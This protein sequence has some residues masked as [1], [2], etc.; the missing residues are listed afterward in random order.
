MT[1][2]GELPRL[3]VRPLAI[4]LAVQVACLTALSGRYGF[5]RDELYFIAAGNHIAPGYID[6]PPI[7]P[8]LA[9]ISVDLFGDTT[10]GLRVVSTVMAMLTVVLVAL[11]ARE[12]GSGRGPQLFAAGAAALSGFVLVVS[13]LVSTSSFDL[14]MWMLISWL[15]LRV[16]RTGD[17]RWWLG[18]GLAVGLALE[19]KWLVV[20]LLA[21]VAIGLIVVGPRTVFRTWWLA[22]GIGVAVLILLP[23]LIWQIQHHFPQ[24]T[25]ASQISATDGGT[26]RIMFIPLQLV[27]LSPVLVPVWF[28]GIRRIWRA[29]ELRW[30]RSLV[31]AYPVLCVALLIVGGKP[32][33]PVPLLLVFLAAGAEPSMAAV[34]WFVTGERTLA[35]V[36]SW[37]G[38]VVAVLISAAISLPV[39]PQRDLGPVLAI[40]PDQGEEVAWPGFVDAVAGAWQ[41]I[42]AGERDTAV[43]LTDNYGE[44][45]AIQ[46]YGYLDGLPTPYSGHM[47]YS[48]WGPPADSMTGPVLLVGQFAPPQ[49]TDCRLI[50][51]YYNEYG[52]HDKE[53]GVPVRICTGHAGP[54]SQLWPSLSHYYD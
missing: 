7:T 54:W 8:L 19:N 3:A 14:L 2:T 20:G 47:S 23:N 46:Q 33:Y 6:Q 30:A 16:L 43:I 52:L 17:G 18:I 44:A 13:H 49:F 37:A 10:Y 41:Q 31:L 32:Y 28:A 4:L 50:T 5:N 51:R 42:P 1:S 22:A 48:A 9:K 25:V 35:K 45:G 15:L 53:W 39:L 26:N 29:A 40:E 24:L 12:F 21:A 34:R 36:A 27:Y 38:V 11:V